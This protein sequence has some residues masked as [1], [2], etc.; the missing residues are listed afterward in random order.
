MLV[1]K[2]LGDIK[3]RVDSILQGNLA[4]LHTKAD[5]MLELG[6]KRPET[7]SCKLILDFRGAPIY[8][9]GSEKTDILE[10]SDIEIPKTRIVS[11]FPVT[12]I[13]DKVRGIHAARFRGAEAGMEDFSVEQ[14]HLNGAL[15]ALFDAIRG[16]EDEIILHHAGYL[17][18]GVGR[19]ATVSVTKFGLLRG[20]DRAELQDVPDTYNS[21]YVRCELV[22]RL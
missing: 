17:T 2:S 4:Y 16:Y 14:A 9:D 19:K 6:L 3:G 13:D 22:D 12:A 10:Y 5:I 18:N 7:R 15:S 1:A 8:E 11:E 21:V 20:F